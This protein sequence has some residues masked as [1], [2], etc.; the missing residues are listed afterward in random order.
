[1]V[2]Y[3]INRPEGFSY[4]F[5]TGVKKKYRV[6]CMIHRFFFSSFKIVEEICS[7]YTKINTREFRKGITWGCV[8]DT[9]YQLEV[10][11]FSTSLES[12][13]NSAFNQARTK[14]HE[15]ITVEH[16]LLSLLDNPE[17]SIVLSSCG[18]N[19]ERLRAGLGIFIDETTP[20]IPLHMEREDLQL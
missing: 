7:V 3:L 4:P 18:A 11:M 10:N 19:L 6:N 16:L 14:R 13:L 12:T 20:Q 8:N 17:A 5:Y 9:V 15:F 2:V 1:M